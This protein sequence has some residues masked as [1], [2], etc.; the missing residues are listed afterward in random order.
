MDSHPSPVRTAPE[1][2]L[3]V[4]ETTTD[5]TP[6]VTVSASDDVGLT[7]D[8]AIDADLNGDDDFL[9]TDEADFGAGSLVDGMAVFELPEL[10]V[11]TIHLRARVTDVAGNEGTSDTQTVEVEDVPDSWATTDTT[12]PSG[13]SL[14]PPRPAAR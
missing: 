4:E 7:A 11:G 3:S 9:D 8:I 13:C 12:H 5:P 2:S 14:T 10:P 6:E 1:V